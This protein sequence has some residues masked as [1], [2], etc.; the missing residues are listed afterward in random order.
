MVAVLDVEQATAAMAAAAPLRTDTTTRIEVW[1]REGFVGTL[2]AFESVQVQWAG[3]DQAMVTVS[4][5]DPLAGVLRSCRRALVRVRIIHGKSQ[6]DG[7]VTV[8]RDSGVGADWRVTAEC[9]GVA[10]ILGAILAYPEPL[11]GLELLQVLRKNVYTG[12]VATGLLSLVALNVQRL[13]RPN[14]QLGIP[15]TVIPINPLFDG[16]PWRTWAL[17]MEPI[18]EV[19]D[20]MLTDGQGWRLRVRQWLPGDEPPMRP[21]PHTKPRIVV[22]MVR[23]PWLHGVGGGHTIF[24]SLARELAGFVGDAVGWIAQG[25]DRHLSKRWDELINGKAI[26]S[27]VWQHGAA[28]VIDANVDNAHPRAAAAVVGGAA[29][30]WLNGMIEDGASLAT[31]QLLASVGVVLPGAGAIVGKGLTNR[32]GTY[33]RLTDWATL[34]DVGPEAYPEVFE[35]ASAALTLDAMQTARAALFEA[36]PDTYVEL[37]VADGMPWRFGADYDIG[38]TCGFWHADGDLYAAPVTSV[39]LSVSRDEGPQMIT[40]LGTPPVVPPGERAR[41]LAAGA[42]TVANALTL[43]Y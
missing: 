31:T 16:S 38:H 42:V 17:A 14:R 29:P 36:A 24:S 3:E 18:S 2:G 21:W 41:R 19:A 10:R 22:D 37:T 35:N 32:V 1:D 28:G 7:R 33:Q 4:G 15:I 20:E 23:A 27:V 34:R 12:P 40:H 13:Q 43:K 6:W 39:E 26:P 11:A 8:A 9:A 30:D 5:R 25:A